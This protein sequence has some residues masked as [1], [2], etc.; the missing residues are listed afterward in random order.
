MNSIGGK[1]PVWDVECVATLCSSSFLLLGLSCRCSN[2]GVGR[3]QRCRLG[4]DCGFVAG[5][6]EVERSGRVEESTRSDRDVVLQPK[7]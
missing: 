4:L 2:G 3:K 5:R 6:V 1:R 7:L